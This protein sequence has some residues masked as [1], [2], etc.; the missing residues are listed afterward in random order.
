MVRYSYVQYSYI[1]V[2]L[3]YYLSVV[4]CPELQGESEV[5]R[6]ALQPQAPRTTRDF[7]SAMK[8]PTSEPAD[9]QIYRSRRIGT[10]FGQEG[11][12]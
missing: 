9:T 10:R 5:L 4:S 12:E 1:E 3:Y 11:D 2:L 8:D 6:E 7:A